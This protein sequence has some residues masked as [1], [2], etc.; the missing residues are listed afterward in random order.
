MRRV[1]LAAIATVICLAI[2]FYIN[3]TSRSPAIPYETVTVKVV[4]VI[5][6]ED[7]KAD[8]KITVEYEGKQYPLRFTYI[9]NTP[10]EGSEMQGLLSDG[11]IYANKES[12]MPPVPVTGVYRMAITASMASGFCT[13]FFFIMRNRGPQELG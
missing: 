6:G 1:I 10:A 7:K 13:L 9:K 2:T 11:E 5:P 4:E 12:L 3:Y 8:P